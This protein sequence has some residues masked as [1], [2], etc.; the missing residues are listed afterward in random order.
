MTAAAWIQLAVIAAAVGAVAP[1][2]GRYLAAVHSPGPAPG[3]RVFLPVERLVY[4]VIRVDPS[5][6]Q[7]WQTYALSVVA[8][9]TVSV[10]WLFLILRF[11]SV[12]PFN[13]TNARAVEPLLAFN[14]ATSFVT[15][16]NWQSYAGETTMSHLSQMAGLVVAQFTAAAVGMSVALA[17]VRGSCTDA[18]RMAVP[19][20]HAVLGN[21]WVDL[22]RNIVRIL[23][24]IA[25]VA[26]LVMVSQGTVQNLE[27]NSTVASI[28]GA[29]QMIPGGPVATQEVLKTLGTNGGG[30]YNVGSAHPFANPNG[31]TNAFELLLVLAIPLPSRSCTGASS[32]AAVRATRSWR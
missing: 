12:L 4:R 24:P 31:L 18:T 10:L 28:T 3:D 25:A 16:T 19:T 32:A 9:G 20:P 8:F 5:N 11:Q 21:F 26:T 23:I 14:V 6:S 13:P 1:L 17:V 22:T 15:G 29:R 30:F 27:G 7:R 2:L